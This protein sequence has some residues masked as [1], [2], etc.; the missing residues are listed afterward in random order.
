MRKH[1]I[2]LAMFILGASVAALA[3]APEDRAR[4]AAE[5]WIVLVDDGQYEQSWVEAS[6]MFQENTPKD[7]WTKKAQTERTSLGSR[8]GRKLKEI[9]PVN[10]LKG[11]PAGQ[12]VQVKYQ[13]SYANKKQAS[14]TIVAVLEGDGTWRVASYT[15][16]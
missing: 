16:N 12:Y 2:L 3:Q 4:F 15:V 6:K 11:L 13:S 1:A 5:Q 14:E 8:L 10:S 7:D 9:K